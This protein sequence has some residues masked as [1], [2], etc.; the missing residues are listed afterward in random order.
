MSKKVMTEQQALYLRFVRDT[1]HGGPFDDSWQSIDWQSFY[2]FARQQALLGVVF[3]GM[4][5]LGDRLKGRV[6]QKL[7][8]EWYSA[9]EA[10]RR[11]NLL[12]NKR[13]VEVTQLFAGAGF[14]SC[15][16]KGQGNTLM[17]PHPLVRTSGDIDIW[18]DADRKAIRQF[19]KSKCAKAEDGD[20]HI[21]FPIF[22]DVP[23]EVHYIP[24]H[25]SR[26]RDQRRLQQWFSSHA[27][28]QFSHRVRLPETDADVCVPTPEFNLVQQLS[29]L[30]SHFFVEG[31]GF[32]QVV[33]YYFVLK[34]V[35]KDGQEEQ[36]FD[37]LGML[38][39]ARGVM[40][41]EHHCLGLEAERLVVAPDEQ[42]GRFI[43]QELLAGGNFGRYDQR[44]STR[45]LGYLARG[46]T[47]TVR[48]LRLVPVFPADALW[49]I[50]RK[51]ENQR[52]KLQ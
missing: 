29:H 35:R 31:I 11:Q 30:R 46:V 20:M 28:P 17:Y 50:L 34:N 4:Q 9:S 44:Y 15:I 1:L 27:G 14:R 40:W 2:V 41:I 22:D 43:L 24:S 16:L 52:W 10:I 48:L 18:I 3:D 5:A 51:I 49:K 33:D 37:H 45:K 13:A 23:V 21:Q 26:P 19:V 36:L 38:K 39:F 42:V 32:R 25:T 6:D 12:L 8:L 7:L 47:D